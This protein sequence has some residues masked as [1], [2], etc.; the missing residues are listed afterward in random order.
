MDIV[1]RIKILRESLDL[2]QYEMSLQL[3]L[4]QGSLS[5]IE[6]RKTKKV[7]DRIIKLICKTYY[8]N[9]N[10]LRFGEGEMKVKLESFSLDEFAKANEATELEIEIMRAYFSLESDFRKKLIEHFKNYLI[11]INNLSKNT[12][13]E[14]TS[15]IENT[16]NKL[17]NNTTKDKIINI[18]SKDLK[19]EINE[20]KYKE[21]S[22]SFKEFVSANPCVQELPEEVQWTYYYAF[23]EEKIRAT[24]TEEEKRKL[25]S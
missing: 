18:N 15:T 11:N 7:S 10:W 3:G 21:V 6:R 12:E 13:D 5:D 4:K 17:M 23:K 1:D 8:V 25:S 22:E 14:T 19:P 24:L 16:N 2:K 9:E 20:K